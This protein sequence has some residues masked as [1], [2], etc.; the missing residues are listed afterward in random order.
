MKLMV[1][2]LEATGYNVAHFEE[3]GSP[4]RLIVDLFGTN[5]LPTGFTTRADSD[6]VAAKL[7]KLNPDYAVSVA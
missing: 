4:D 7:Q 1:I 5:V 2:K 3:D 6:V